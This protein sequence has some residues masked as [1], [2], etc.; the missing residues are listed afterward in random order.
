MDVNRDSDGTYTDRTYQ[1]ATDATPPGRDEIPTS[2]DLTAWLSWNLYRF[3]WDNA[4]DIFITE[5]PYEDASSATMNAIHSSC[6]AHLETEASVLLG[7]IALVVAIIAGPGLAYQSGCLVG[8]SNALDRCQN[9]AGDNGRRRQGDGWVIGGGC[10]GGGCGGG[11]C[12]G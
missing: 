10:G 4:T 3:A 8:C 9:R 6:W 5:C 2:Y 11:G 7:R 12:G 1:K